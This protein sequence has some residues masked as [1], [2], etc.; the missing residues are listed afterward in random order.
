[1]FET[2][3]P[4]EITIVRQG[5]RLWNRG[6][7]GLCGRGPAAEAHPQRMFFFNDCPLVIK[8]AIEN[9]HL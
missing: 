3:V 1:M 4:G 5:N 6:R 9:D 2:R 7:R 8:I